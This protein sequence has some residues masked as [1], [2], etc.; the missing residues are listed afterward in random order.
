M[1]GFPFPLSKLLSH[2]SPKPNIPPPVYTPSA[3]SLV[4]TALPSPLVRVVLES[5]DAQAWDGSSDALTDWLNA[6]WAKTGFKVS[7][8]TICFT[9]RANGRNA[10]MGVGDAMEVHAVI[11]CWNVRQDVQLG[12]PRA[13]PQLQQRRNEADAPLVYP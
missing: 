2:H 8:E 13:S 11:V 9:L 4:H 6:R 12:P 7:K 3:V 1:K 10:A 5:F